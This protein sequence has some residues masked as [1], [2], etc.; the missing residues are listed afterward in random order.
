V[1]LA[2]G[3]VADFEL[4]ELALPETPRPEFESSPGLRVLLLE[5]FP[6]LPAGDEPGT[7]EPALGFVSEEAAVLLLVSEEDVMAV[8]GNYREIHLFEVHLLEVH[9]L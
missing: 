3:V 4:A 1:L 2:V 6:E 5:L 7:P 8:R 9:L